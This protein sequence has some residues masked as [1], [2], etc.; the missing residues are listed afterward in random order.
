MGDFLPAPDDDYDED[1]DED[2]PP[3][4]VIWDCPNVKK[5]DI[6]GADGSTIPGWECGYCPP[7]Q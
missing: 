4:G 1:E 6:I 5:T 3:L 7:R 2:L